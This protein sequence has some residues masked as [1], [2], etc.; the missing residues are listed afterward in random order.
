MIRAWSIGSAG[1]HL[2]TWLVA[3]NNNATPCRSGAHLEHHWGEAAVLTMATQLFLR[4][5]EV[6]T[7]TQDHVRLT[8]GHNPEVGRT[9][10]KQSPEYS[11][12]Q[13]LWYT[14]HADSQQQGQPSQQ[15]PRPQQQPQQ[16][17][18]LELPPQLAPLA[19]DAPTGAHPGS[20]PYMDGVRESKHKESKHRESKHSSHCGP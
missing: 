7:L 2:S 10:S 3:R 18:T 19:K 14:K 5:N 1:E 16:G 4:P 17:S 20:G 12:Y 8:H 9:C 13:D 6:L 15:Q 11:A